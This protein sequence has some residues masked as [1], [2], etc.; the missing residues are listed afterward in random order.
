MNANLAAS[1]NSTID[2]SI[3]RGARA[4]GWLLRSLAWVAPEAAARRAADLFLTPPRPA[5]PERECLWL[6]SAFRESVQIDGRE[7]AVWTWPGATVAAPTILLVH[8]W[9]GRGSQ[10]GAFVAPLRAA[11]VRVVA[12]DAPAHGAS[13]GRKTN[14]IQF[15]TA[16][17]GM[18][19][20]F[21]E[22]G[23]VAGLV[24]HS[25]GAAA[26]TIALSRGSQVARAVFVAPAEDYDHF[27]GRFRRALG[28][29][30]STV[31]RMQRGIEKRVG[32]EWSTVR[33]SR[34]APALRQPLLVV[35]DE[36]DLEVPIAHGETIASRWPEA[37]L[38]RTRGLGHRRI[39][40]DADVIDEASR[41]LLVAG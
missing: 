15:S 6:D 35:H 5:T 39:L 36:D 3:P 25:F 21:A 1:R 4:A 40:R 7:L 13:D 37:R 12:F 9:G 16:L 24:A 34:L 19:E 26:A 33:G 38:H 29:D 20:R 23:P 27:T 41:F 10:L 17:G 18:L 32:V 14:L 30:P 8:G 28:L 11:G 31:E 2:R 22:Q